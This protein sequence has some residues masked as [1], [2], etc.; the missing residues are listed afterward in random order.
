MS[1]RKFPEVRLFT[2]TEVCRKSPEVLG[3]YA[4]EVAGSLT[5]SVSPQ[6]PLRARARVPARGG[7]RHTARLPE[8]SR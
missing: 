5:G 2:D 1:G 4:P 6:T 7:P 8:I 3:I